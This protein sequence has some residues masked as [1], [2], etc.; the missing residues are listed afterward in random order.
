MWENSSPEQEAMLNL[1]PPHI[2]FQMLAFERDLELQSHESLVTI[3]KAA[4]RDLILERSSRK[5]QEHLVARLERQ[6]NELER[7]I[8]RRPQV[9]RPIKI[10]IQRGS[11]VWRYD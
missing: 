4:F 3:A 11:E 9:R 10:F 7:A 6:L 2:Q 5:N 1:I 8:I